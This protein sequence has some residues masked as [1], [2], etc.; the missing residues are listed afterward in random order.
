MSVTLTGSDALSNALA[1]LAKAGDAG[2]RDGVVAGS[3]KL[4]ALT[5]G[6]LGGAPRWSRKGAGRTGP[7]YDSGR[8]PVNVP[9]GG[10][11]G[12]LTGNLRKNV[13]STKPRKD[14]LGWSG[15]VSAMGGR[16]GSTAQNLYAPK[17]E[18]AY[19]FL[20]PALSEFDSLAPAIFEAAWAARI[21][22]I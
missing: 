7:A 5:R 17:V 12:S 13:H 18:D 11:A 2:A 21:G 4:V 16:G 20:R 22:R 15:K 1:A 10:P 9:R 6:N 19:P 8:R 14:V 3:R